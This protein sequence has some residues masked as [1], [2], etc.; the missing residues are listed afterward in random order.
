MKTIHAA[1]AGLTLLAAA[2]SP[3]FAQSGEEWAAAAEGATWA[4]T[5]VLTAAAATAS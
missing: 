4:P 3:A 5:R 1:S 2:I